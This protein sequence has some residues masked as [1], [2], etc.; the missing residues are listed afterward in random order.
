M[1]SLPSDLMSL[2]NLPTGVPSIPGLP[3]VPDLPSMPALA[4]GLRDR[5]ESTFESA[6]GAVGQATDAASGAVGDAVDTAT[7]VVGGAVDA[8]KG[9]AGHALD[10]A[11]GAVGQASGALAATST[12]ELVRRLFDPLAARLKAEL[13]LDRE[14]AGFVTD[15]RR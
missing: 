6:R 3:S 13:R 11:K 7:G 10:A 9:A 8:A 2:R 1:P 12:D 4:G 5:A 14:R 15:L